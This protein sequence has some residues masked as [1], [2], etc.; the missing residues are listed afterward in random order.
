[1]YSS[2]K[3]YSYF[4]NPSRKEHFEKEKVI[5]LIIYNPA[6][7]YERDMKEVLD[8]YLAT[9][10]H[11]KSYFI[12]LREQPEPVQI[13]KNVMYIQGTETFIPGILYKT[14]KAMEYCL[15]HHEFD[16]LIRSNISTV[17]DFSKMKADEIISDYSGCQP[18]NL[19]WLDHKYGIR[20]NSLWGTRYLQGTHMILTPHAVKKI[21]N[22]QYSLREDVIDDVA[23]GIILGAPQKY[24]NMVH[25]TDYSKTAACYRNKTDGN[26]NRDVDR[27]KRTVEQLMKSQK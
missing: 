13:E 2:L 12:T 19:Q 5:N 18:F 9:Q 4:Y 10:I 23:L 17:L 8:T 21:V 27:M 1:M 14:V 25:N 3:D 20:D 15:L 6:V 11:V 7:D 16:Y 26:R 22:E 24:G